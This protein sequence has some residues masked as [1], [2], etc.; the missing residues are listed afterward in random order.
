[1]SR[2][3]RAKQ[4]KK[5]ANGIFSTTFLIFFLATAVNNDVIAIEGDNY[6][7]SIFGTA[8][9]AISDQPYS[10]DKINEHGTFDQDSKL[11]IQLDYQFNNKFSAT[12]QAK[13]APANDKDNRWRPELSWAFLSYRPSD[14]LLLRIGKLRIPSLLY[15]E[16]MDVGMSYESAARLPIEVYKSS[17]IYDFWGISSSKSFELASGNS[18]VWDAYIGYAQFKDRTWVNDSLPNVAKYGANYTGLRAKAIGTVVSWNSEDLQNTLRFGLHYASARRRDGK[19]VQKTPHRINTPYGY[20]YNLDASLPGQGKKD[21]QILF[22]T[23]GARWHLG[24]EFYFISEAVHR[25]AI[26]VKNGYD[27]NSFSLNLLTNECIEII[28]SIFLQHANMLSSVS[29]ISS[30]AEKLKVTLSFEKSMELINSTDIYFQNTRFWPLTSGFNT[31][32]NMPG[33]KVTS[34]A[35]NAGK[36][37]LCKEYLTTPFFSE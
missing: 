8:G 21:L 16:N 12:V 32:N 36:A 30:S 7:L 19:L 29:N 14:D 5:L 26:G 17:S 24:N 34:E 20:Y 9:Y 25:T 1:M 22:F 27:S 23:L 3:I 10:Y 6:S 33:S 4:N 31:T 2:T 28:F 15:T 37:K 35:I 18:I 13:L 11:G